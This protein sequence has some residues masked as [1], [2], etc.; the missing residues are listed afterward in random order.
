MNAVG[1]WIVALAAALASSTAPA[2]ESD[3][4][5]AADIRAIAASA[6]TFAYPLVLIDATRRTDLSDD[7]VRGRWKP[8]PLKN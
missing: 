5:T 3:K 7:A 8:P 2:S 1:Y 6:Y 4:L